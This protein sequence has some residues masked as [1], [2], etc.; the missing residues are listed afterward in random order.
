[1]RK[2]A[3]P[4]STASP[5]VAATIGAARHAR[6]DATSHRAGA[7]ARWAF[8]LTIILV[9]SAGLRFYDLG[10]RDIWIDE[11]NGVLI[12]Q[13]P[14][15]E[16]IAGLRLDSN[17]P[18]YYLLLKAW[19]AVCGD[20]EAAVRGLSAVCGLAL[21]GAVALIGRRMASAEV[22]LLAA[23]LLA[24][25][26][27][28]IV[29]SQ[30]ARMYVLLA[31]L[32]LLATYWLWRAIT[33]RPARFVAAYGITLLAALYTHNCALY[34]L[35]AHAIVVWWSGALRRQPWRWVVC[36]AGVA[37]G[38]A[39]W[40]PVLLG[41][42]ANPAQY[43]WFAPVW[44]QLGWLGALLKTFHSF[45]PGGSAPG[46]MH[47]SEPT[48]YGPSE[49]H[50]APRNAVY[51]HRGTQP[52]A[53]PARQAR[54]RGARAFTAGHCRRAA[55]RAGDSAAAHVHRPAPGRRSDCVRAAHAPTTSPAGPTN[56][57]FPASFC[58]SRWA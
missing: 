29:Y 50:L 42:L 24:C 28:Q 18:L 46:Y 20:S 51:R 33:T 10:A 3:A 49:A 6:H 48:E 45:A 22:G 9:L 4:S 30:Q 57:S 12:A 39:P 13:Q 52:A 5:A 53:S 26:P 32:A 1:M 34:L 7:A 58:C 17:P 11:A 31:L 55:A 37:A 8:G 21:V 47:I 40:V 43:C 27:I 36:G 14:P 35:P 19:M 56:W 16:L 38:Y 23:A 44:Q 15:A 2:R 41:Q 54:R 25:S